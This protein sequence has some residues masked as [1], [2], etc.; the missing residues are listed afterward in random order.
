MLYN[1]KDLKEGQYFNFNGSNVEYIIDKVED[2][3]ITYHG[4]NGLHTFTG[5]TVT[6]VFLTKIKL[7][8]N[9]E[10]SNISKEDIFYF[11]KSSNNKD[12]KIKELENNGVYIYALEEPL[13]SLYLKKED[14]LDI[15]ISA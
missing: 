10:F 7:I 14:F 12:Y 3:S 13:V 1:I 11:R 9:L 5:F 6:D 2:T 4:A 8:E 15:T